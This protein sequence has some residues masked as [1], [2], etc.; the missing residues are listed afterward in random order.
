[1]ATWY[2][3][4]EGGSDNNSGD[5]FAV[6]LTNTDGVANGT[7]TFTSAGGGFTGLSGRKIF[8]A[9]KGGYT[10]SSV[11]NNT[12]VVLNTTV[13]AGTGLTFTVGGR[14][15]TG[16]AIGMSNM[17]GI[18][19]NDTVRFM[20]SPAP[21]S[22]GA[23]T[24]WFDRRNS[25]MLIGTSKTTISDCETAWTGG[26]ANVTC[27]TNA[28]AIEGSNSVQIAINTTFTTGKAAY[29]DL[30]STTDFSSKQIVTFWFKQTSGTLMSGAASLRLC[31]DALGVTSVNTLTIPAVAQLNVWYPIAIDAG[32]ALSSTVRSVAYY[33]S[34]DQGAQTF[35]I[36]AVK[37]CNSPALTRNISLQQ[38]GWTTVTNVTN[39]TSTNRKEG[40]VSCQSAVLGAFVTGKAG[41]FATGTLDLSAYQQVSF[42]F[43][44]TVGTLLA[45]GGA[46]LHLCSDTTGD[47]TVDTIPIPAITDSALSTWHPMTV[48]TGGALGS[49]IRSIAL[50]I[51]TDVGAQTFLIDDII[52]CKAPSADDSLT[53]QSLIG[54]SDSWGA[55]GA[56]TDTFYAIRAINGNTV[57]LDQNPNQ[58]NATAAR[59]WGGTSGFYSGYKREGIKTSYLNSATSHNFFPL[60]GTGG[61]GT[62]TYSGGWDRTNMST[63]NL[64][65]WYD[66]GNGLGIG[67]G[68]QFGGFSYT[69]MNLFAASRY[70]T[71]VYLTGASTP[72]SFQVGTIVA[73][74]NCTNI[75]ISIDSL[76]NCTIDNIVAVNNNN[77]LGSTAA[78]SI[79]GGCT[80]CTFNTIGSVANNSMTGIQLTSEDNNYNTFTTISSLSYNAGNANLEVVGSHY[81]TF[82]TISACSL[83]TTA[84]G[85]S[86]TT[87]HGNTF[88]TATCVS[89]FNY[90][91]NL[92]SAND[93][94]FGTLT[95]TS[96]TGG[97]YTE[98]S[99]FKNRVGSITATGN[100][101]GMSLGGS[102]SFFNDVAVSGNS[103]N[104]RL[105]GGYR[106][107]VN[108]MSSADVTIS[109][110]QFE[111]KRLF[112]LY[113]S[114]N[115]GMMTIVCDYGMIQA[116]T[117]Q[118][119]TGS[120]LAWKLSPTNSNRNASYPLEVTLARFAVTANL[121]YTV[122]CYS[123]RSSS[124]ISASL[125]C[126]GGQ[127]PGV[128]SNVSATSTESANTWGGDGT[129]GPLAISFT[130][131]VSGVIEVCGR[132]S[133]GSVNS[134]WFD[135]LTVSEGVTTVPVTLDYSSVWSGPGP[136]PL[137]NGSGS[138]VVLPNRGILSG[139]IL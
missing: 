137:V 30:G 109:S 90:G 61:S 138:T 42:W 97:G 56:D 130:P 117:D 46:S 135:D 31:S 29:F 139:P 7:T 77:T 36:D 26:T 63:Q 88:G 106:N 131:T 2:C 49:S 64:V 89:N 86:V 103:T 118:R 107:Y 3:D 102:D 113:D 78:I 11:T 116:A 41:Y 82:G 136:D 44:Q 62:I 91:V 4:Y 121:T 94:V 20:G 125:F 65:T 115:S 48:D 23:D 70:S 120:G 114:G 59:G 25:V 45:T 98:I 37:A 17:E 50:Y 8:I 96:N 5:S 35:Q 87:A 13:S 67:L 111:N 129:G 122:R 69:A 100:G 71:G 57:F 119:H 85:I 128:G 15:K 79:L 104:F 21:T 93:N 54:R 51:N 126:L 53:L 72:A 55:G 101:I 83:N 134:V 52:A 74:N 27:T 76:T 99:T 112:I 22:L 12:T 19:G 108:T 32:V 133:G 123:R 73:A 68:R 58:S 14:R 24:L 28:D 132:A 47:V 60:G 33:V 92:S 95:V 110:S 124:G 18:A 38:T 34:P 81:N 80:N 6:T 105:S 40:T 127:L 16:T 9:T 43:N 75:G 66:G 1:M 39:N 84:H 10:I